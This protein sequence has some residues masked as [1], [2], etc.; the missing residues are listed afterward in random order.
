[1]KAIKNYTTQIAIEKT[2]AEMHKLLA[3]H[4]ATAIMTE[5][6]DEGIVTN[7]SFKLKTATGEIPFR[8]PS[9]IDGVL[10]CLK[11]S[12]KVPR[13]LETREQAARVSWRIVRDWVDAQLAFVQAQQVDSMQVFLPYAQISEDGMTVYDKFKESPQL[14]L[15]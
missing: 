6:D 10:K 4:K 12:P 15:K 11:Q 13:R 1:M 7:L 8:L 3:M 14:L 5:Y 2:V 9:N